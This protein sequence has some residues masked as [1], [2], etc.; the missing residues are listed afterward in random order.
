MN[1][2]RHNVVP[3]MSSSEITG[4]HDSATGTVSYI[5]TDPATKRAAIIDPT[6]NYEANS[7]RTSTAAADELLATVRKQGLTVEWILETHVHADHLTA[8]A[9]LKTQTGAKVAIGTEIRS[10]QQTFGALFNVLPS[11]KPNAGDF[12]HTFRDGESF[13]IGNL[14]ASAMHTPGHTPACSAY[15]IGDALFV[16]DTIF[17]PD[18]GTARC[19]FPGGDAAMLYRSI[20]KI[21]ALPDTTRIF[22]GHDYGP[23]GR[24]IAWQTTVKA[25]KESNTQIGGGVPLEA[26]VAMRTARDKTLALPNLILPAVQVNIRAGR[27]PDAEA[28]GIAYL[29]L[30]LNAF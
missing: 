25:Q 1:P 29:K 22:V 13:S 30:P 2:I 5:V 3:L 14:K 16:G 21:L 27:L 15:L 28:N 12:D 7:G 8:A 11:V 20:Q 26:F 19:D 23:N 18:Y 4:F 6:L 17:M 9:Y 10:V 24:P